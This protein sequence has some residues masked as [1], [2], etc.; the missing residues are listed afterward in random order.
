MHL[1]IRFR[2]NLSLSSCPNS[3]KLLQQQ[4]TTFGARLMHKFILLALLFV[5]SP[6]RAE[7]LTG[8]D[9][10]EQC[11]SF[12]DNDYSG[13][14]LCPA[15]ISGIVGVHDTFMNWGQHKQEWCKPAD[16]DVNNLVRLVTY[17]MRLISPQTLT[18]GAENLVAFAL[19]KL[20]PCNQ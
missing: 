13:D 15:F 20:F 1:F 14:N 8:Y 4:I 5:F 19:V 3:G 2:R 16:I 7:Y 17:E 12:I 11:S 9:L 10:L 18:Y 6:V